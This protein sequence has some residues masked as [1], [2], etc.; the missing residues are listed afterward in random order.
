MINYQY[1]IKSTLLIN[2]ACRIS[3]LAESY[4]IFTSM[5]SN[6]DGFTADLIIHI[7]IIHSFLLC[8]KKNERKVSGGILVASMKNLE[9]LA[10]AAVLRAVS[11]LLHFKICTS[12]SLVNT[13]KHYFKDTDFTGTLCLILRAVMIHF[14]YLSQV[15]I[16]DYNSKQQP[17]QCFNKKEA[18]RS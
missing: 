17:Q 16:C 13:I 1:F 11:G 4:I 12:A 10:A 2:V 9:A 18:K 7:D 14:Y 3:I 8:H 15:A 6:L 5:S